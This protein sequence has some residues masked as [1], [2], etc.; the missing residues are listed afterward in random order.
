MAEMTIKLTGWKAVA[1]LA[2]IVV[3]AILH[4]TFIRR[5]LNE[6]AV[7]EIRPYIQGEVIT[8][9]VGDRDPWEMSK[10]ELQAA[11][12][13]AMKAQKVE[14]KNV[15]ASGFGSEV[16]VRVEISVDGAPPPDGRT[17]RYYRMDHSYLLGWTY[18]KEVNAFAYYTKL[19]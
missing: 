4:Q 15:T 10:T 11:G 19:W 2:A 17:V 1:A 5:S 9:A 7:E 16:V 18:R 13:K 3:L 8:A 12:E 6:E 14:L